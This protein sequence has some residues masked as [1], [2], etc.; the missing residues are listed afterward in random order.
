MEVEQIYTDLSGSNKKTGL[1]IRTQ[2]GRLAREACIT[3]AGV[4]IPLVIYFQIYR[5]IPESKRKLFENLW[6]HHRL[7]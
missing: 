2:S 5:I 4:V 1:D 7:Y 3:L 6:F